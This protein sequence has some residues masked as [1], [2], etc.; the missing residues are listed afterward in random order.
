MKKYIFFAAL[1]ALTSFGLSS[2]SD[3][4]TEG[5]SRITYYPTIEIKGESPLLWAKG[6]AFVEPGYISLMNGE[7]VS[8][9]VTV[10]SDVD[11]NQSG[12]Y[13]IT[14]T[15][16]KNSDGFSASVRRRVVVFD[17]SDA[18]EGLYWL[19][20]SSYRVRDGENTLYGDSYPIVIMNNGDGTY[21][22]DDMLGGWYYYR[23]GYGSDY[24]MLSTIKVA[25][26]GTITLDKSYVPGWADSHDAFK[27]TFDAATGTITMT[28][29][30]AKM[31][32]VQTWVKQTI[33]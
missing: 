28:V 18:V 23:A 21:S 24:G 7:D 16:P 6:T 33:E 25:T 14:Y 3:N 29:T 26:D 20:P 5:L 13:T 22:V 30:Y 17:K 31:D 10:R 8:S 15:T 12:D 11:T 27:G 4:E 1:L 19:D 32:F 9:Q 2:C